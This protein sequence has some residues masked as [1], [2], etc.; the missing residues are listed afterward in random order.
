MSGKNKNTKKEARTVW[1]K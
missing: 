1:K